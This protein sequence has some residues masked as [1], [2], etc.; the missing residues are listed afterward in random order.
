M[1]LDLKQSEVDRE[2]NKVT[3]TVAY[4]KSLEQDLLQ[5]R[6]ES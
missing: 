2:R 1:Q 6:E 3:T 5:A 4:A